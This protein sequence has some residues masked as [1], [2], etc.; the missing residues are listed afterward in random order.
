VEDRPPGE[1]PDSALIA[2][3]RAGDD[4][5]FAVLVQRYSDVAFRAAYV[6]LGEADAAADAAQEGFISVHRSLDRFRPA[7]PFRP[8]L[9]R[10]VGNRARNL[11]RGAG[12]RTAATLQAAS[13]VAAR[14]E[15][16]ASPEE[17]LAADEERARVLAA[18][19]A[20]GAEDRAVIA[21]R[22][23]LDLSEAETAEL[24]GVA[25]GTVK[26]RLFRARDRLRGQLATEG[27][28]DG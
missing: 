21:C 26:S 18:V 2:S 25:R 14:G 9:L 24:L 13:A 27:R 12:R 19:N 16:A 20:L 3:A 7:E 8:W 6:V 22:Y 5:A 15:T 1:Q 17:L 28:T 11:R 23:F 4:A 10:I